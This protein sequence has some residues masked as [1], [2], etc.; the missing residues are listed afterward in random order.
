[1]YSAYDIGSDCTGTAVKNTRDEKAGEGFD[2]EYREYLADPSIKSFQPG[3]QVQPGFDMKSSS[4]G[5]LAGTFCLMKYTLEDGK[6]CI[7]D[8]NTSLFRMEYEDPAYC[9]NVEAKDGKEYAAF[10]FERTYDHWVGFHT[11]YSRTISL[12]NIA[13]MSYWMLRP[14][15]GATVAETPVSSQSKRA[16]LRWGV[17]EAVRDVRV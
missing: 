4:A 11:L 5:M 15:M 1:M 6:Y 14:R 3:G 17:G 12:C 13:Q 16:G 7:D 2:M 8:E 10:N 9:I